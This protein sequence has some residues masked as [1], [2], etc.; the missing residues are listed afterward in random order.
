MNESAMTRT[1]LDR[2][3]KAEPSWFVWKITEPM[4]GGKPD[5]LIIPRA[6]LGHVWVEFKRCT[7]LTNPNPVAQLTELQKVTIKHLVSLG[8]TVLL[9]GYVGSWQK[10]RMHRAFVH[11]FGDT[12]VP[13]LRF[14]EFTMTGD[15]AVPA[16]L[17]YLRN[18]PWTNQRPSVAA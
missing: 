12:T 3:R 9:V 8:Q 4:G 16:L 18:G 17:R 15:P 13:G 5:A 6:E 14:E 1:L 11:H 10:V 2:I 7:S